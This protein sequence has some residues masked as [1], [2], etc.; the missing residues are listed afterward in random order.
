MTT[1][2]NKEE[3]YFKSTVI[4][5]KILS[6]W[7]K[8][9]EALAAKGFTPQEETIENYKVYEQIHKLRNR[10]ARIKEHTDKEGG[11]YVD[12][13]GFRQTSPT[14]EEEQ[15]IEILFKEV[16]QT[17]YSW[18]E[19]KEIA[20]KH[21]TSNLYTNIAF[22]HNTH[23]II[24]FFV[25]DVKVFHLS[26]GQDKNTCKKDVSLVRERA[27]ELAKD[28]NFDKIR[29][30]FSTESK[31]HVDEY[32]KRMIL[33]QYDIPYIV[34]KSGGK[35]KE[36][37]KKVAFELDKGT[38]L[39]PETLEILFG[40]E[41]NNRSL[42]VTAKGTLDSLTNKNKLN[43]LF[44]HCKGT[45][46]VLSCWRGTI[47]NSDLNSITLP[48]GEVIYSIHHSEIDPVYDALQNHYDFTYRNASDLEF[49]EESVEILG[50]VMM[51]Q[52]FRDGNKRTAKCLF[53]SMLMSRGIVPPIV[54]LNQ[55]GNDLWYKFAHGRDS[56]Y[57]EA[58]VEVLEATV[59]VAKQFKENSFTQPLIV[60]DR[61][62]DRKSLYK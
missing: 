29:E 19:V 50:D 16:L 5:E 12:E 20:R 1:I 25:P 31:D 23:E 22:P 18:R 53:N 41:E 47:T 61:D 55:D 56:G 45:Q 57:P 54:D 35:Y 4:D 32:L 8:E 2:T 42:A 58:K 9:R 17:N 46:N 44:S 3:S 24:D 28:L 38:K 48:G 59:D 36:S 21:S 6:K 11:L 10:I 39:S 60:S 51:S 13:T 52:V 40:D 15:I 7:R 62:Y 49:V 34:S 27:R 30:I 43:N 33:S 14:D 37:L 26:F